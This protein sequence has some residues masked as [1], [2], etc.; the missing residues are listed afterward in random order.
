MAGAGPAAWVLSRLY[1]PPA[2]RTCNPW[3][4][5]VDTDAMIH[6]SL[7]RWEAVRGP[8]DMDCTGLAAGVRPRCKRGGVHA[9]LS[10]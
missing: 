5:S 6:Y 7:A 1:V 8:D 2:A 3:V 4:L 10:A 9:R